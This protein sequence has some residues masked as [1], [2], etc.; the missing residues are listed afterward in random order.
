MWGNALG[1]C[2]SLV[3]LAGIA[4]ALVYVDSLNRATAPTALSRDARHV[5]QTL[6]LP[7][8]PETLLPELTGPPDAAT[9]VRR[10][11]DAYHADPSTYDSIARGRGVPENFDS[12][13]AITPILEAAL[14]PEM[15]LLGGG[16]VV[17]E[18]VTFR[19]PRAP[20]DALRALG[21]CLIQAGLA[22]ESRAPSAASRYYNAAL[23]LGAKMFK[24]RLVHDELS[25]GM[26]LMSEA[27]LR[28]AA[29][30]SDPARRAALDAF[31]PQLRSFAT[32]RITPLWQVLSSIDDRVA[33]RHAGDVIV[34]A[35]HARERVWR[36]EA[37][38]TLARYRFRAARRADSLAA[39]RALEELA[40][41]EPDPI[42]RA[43][44]IA[45]RDM[46]VEEYRML[47]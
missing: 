15:T 30:T 28:L 38:F 39:A 6:D 4:A 22:S 26:S 36:V 40:G 11:A 8:A 17:A 7:V 44:A 27:S 25:R 19:K 42:V 34:L 3:L 47:R 24:E 31:D 18:V 14:S 33:A 1:W 13:P 43:A 29:L 2:I 45:A 21:A 5:E 32:E 16:A 12:L 9:H 10:A 20:L 41:S 46:T 23:A 37:A 35:R